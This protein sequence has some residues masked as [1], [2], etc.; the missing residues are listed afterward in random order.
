MGG[1]DT[2]DLLSGL[3]H[4]V[5]QG[6][7]DPGRLGVSGRSYG[8]FMTAWLITQD[9]RFAAAVAVSPATNQVTEHLV[10]NI[11]HFVATFLADS[12]T[13][14]RGK[15]YERSPIVHARKAKTPTMNICGALDRC[16]PP[17]EAVQFHRAL[18]E[19]GVASILVTYP[20]EGHGVRNWPAAI[21]FAARVVGW[22]E[23]H[24]A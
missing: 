16:T 13:R 18:Q 22:F 7:A 11:P 9:S 17:E 12:Y 6:I 3:D 15:Y 23:E 21:D 14:P 24:M 4:L 20:E 2:Y 10:S 8:G 1:A 19:N 5:K